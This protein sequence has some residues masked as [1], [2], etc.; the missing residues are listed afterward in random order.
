[1]N[2]C[3]CCYVNKSIEHLTSS[4]KVI[5]VSSSEGLDQTPRFIWTTFTLSYILKCQ[6]F[7]CM[8]VF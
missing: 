6:S 7:G 8:D 2:E 5:I 3:L 4:Y 1:M